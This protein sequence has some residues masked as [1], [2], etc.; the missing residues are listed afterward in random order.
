MDKE[1][2]NVKFMS[3][4]NDLQLSSIKQLNAIAPNIQIDKVLLRQKKLYEQSVEEQARDSKGK[5]IPG[6]NDIAAAAKGQKTML[7]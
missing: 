6:A 4:L 5:A 1:N 2:A 3:E 7:L